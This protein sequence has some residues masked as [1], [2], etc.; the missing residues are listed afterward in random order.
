MF[1]SLQIF[2]VNAFSDVRVVDEL[3]GVAVGVSVEDIDTQLT[4]LLNKLRTEGGVLDG[5]RETVL[6]V[7]T[8]QL[9]RIQCIEC[10]GK[11]G[12]WV[13]CADKMLI[14]WDL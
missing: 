6:N 3:T 12:E 11:E 5:G 9:T 13:F 10:L 1:Y 4:V 7:I 14:G 2:E 8:N